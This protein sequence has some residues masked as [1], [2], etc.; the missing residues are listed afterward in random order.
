MQLPLARR[1]FGG[2]RAG[3]QSAKWLRENGIGGGRLE[4]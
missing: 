3:R 4:H 2:K 1:H